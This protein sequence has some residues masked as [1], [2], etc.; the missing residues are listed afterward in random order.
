[1]CINQSLTKFTTDINRYFTLHVNLFTVK[2]LVL[3]IKYCSEHDMITN[4]ITSAPIE[5][6]KLTQS[7][8][9]EQLNQF[10]ILHEKKAYVIAFMSL[11]NQDDALDVVQDVMIKFVVKYKL[12]NQTDWTSLFYRMIQNRITDFHRQNTQKRKYFGVFSHDTEDNIVEQVADE[13]HVSALKQIDNN[14]KIE[15]L[16]QSLTTLPKRQLQ[17]F[18]CRIWEGLSVAQTA[19]SMKCSQGSVKTHLFRALNQIRTQFKVNSDES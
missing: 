15:N 19:Q 6:T 11:K 5:M 9:T 14:M 13:N 4:S 17:A 7:E 3:Q 16:Q 8:L 18:I 1:M 10:F 12:K 2:T